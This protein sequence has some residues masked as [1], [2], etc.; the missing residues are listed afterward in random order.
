MMWLIKQP[1]IHNVKDAINCIHD[2]VSLAAFGLL[3]GLCK[4]ALKDLK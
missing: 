3:F 2:V 1:E 4:Y